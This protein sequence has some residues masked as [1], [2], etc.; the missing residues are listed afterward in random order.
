MSTQQT[1]LSKKLHSF[2]C[3]HVI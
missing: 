1:A 3:T 2:Y